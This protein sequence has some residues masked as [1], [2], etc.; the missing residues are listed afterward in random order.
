MLRIV[1]ILAI[2]VMLCGCTSQS[3]PAAT[4]AGKSSAVQSKQKVAD[5][6]SPDAVTCRNVV[7]TGSR[8]TTRYCMSNKDW[9][10]REK[11]TQEGARSAMIRTSLN[12]QQTQNMAGQ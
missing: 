4:A 11:I 5:L 6:K 7:Q 1:S 3:T 9:K 8:F 10:A 12:A 2:L